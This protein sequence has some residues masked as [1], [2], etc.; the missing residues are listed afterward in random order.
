LFWKNIHRGA[1]NAEFY[2]ELVKQ[3]LQRVNK[4]VED[5]FMETKNHLGVLLG[6]AIVL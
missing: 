1:L 3:D 5:G 4:K 6:G 2:A